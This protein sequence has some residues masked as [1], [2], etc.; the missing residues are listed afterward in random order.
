WRPNG[1][2]S[3]LGN[4]YYG[5]DWLGLPDRRRVHSDNSI[6]VKYL[7][8]PASP[9]EKGAFSLTVDVGCESGAGIS[10]RGGAGGPA[11]NFSG[12]MLYNRNW[13]AHETLGLTLGGGAMNNPGRYLV[14]VPPI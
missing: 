13:F 2:V 9:V 14:L 5:K 10:C 1:S 6:E 8:Q 12:F 7:D 11:Q 4:Q 3:L